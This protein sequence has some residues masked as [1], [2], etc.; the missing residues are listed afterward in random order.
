MKYDIALLEKEVPN[1]LNG[2]EIRSLYNLLRSGGEAEVYPI[3]I[4]AKEH[5][6]AAMGFITAEAAE[7]IRYDYQSS[8]LNDFVASIMD[9]MELENERGRYQFN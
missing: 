8:G 9:D 5:E 3:E 2:Y 7:Q 4:E 1:G 6:S